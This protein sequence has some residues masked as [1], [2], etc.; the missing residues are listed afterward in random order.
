MIDTD[1]PIHAPDR[2]TGP[3]PALIIL[4]TRNQE[5]HEQTQEKL[6]ELAATVK[7]HIESEPRALS[8]AV[9]D[10]VS[11][12]LASAF[13]GGDAIGHRKKHEAEIA[14]ADE[15]RKTAKTL[16]VEI[17]K[18]LTTAFALWAVYALWLAAVKGVAT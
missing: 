4:L 12:A 7:S 11:Q 3:D 8:C 15:R 13:P 17:V 5:A 1:D 10:G 18:G 2:R 6:S 9:A 16:L 14:A